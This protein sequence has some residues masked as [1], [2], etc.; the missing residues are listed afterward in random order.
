MYLPDQDGGL[1]PTSRTL[2]A[3][4]SVDSTVRIWQ[5]EETDRDFTCLQS[6]SFGNGFALDLAL[7]VLQRR[8]PLLA[9]G[10]DD[11]KL[12]F[13][14][15]ADDGK[16]VRSLSLT[17]H[18]DWIRAVQITADDNGDLLVATCSQDCFIRLWRVVA[19]VNQELHTVKV[20]EEDTG[21][22]KLKGNTLCPSWEGSGICFSVVLESVMAGH[23]QWVYGLHWQPPIYRDGT[24]YQEQCLLSA[25]MDKTMII[26]K[27]DSESGVW[28]DHVRVGEVGGNT[29]GLYGCQFS[30]DGG[31]ILAHG[32]QGALHLWKKSASIPD[33]STAQWSPSPVVSGHFGGVQDI[34]WEPD[35]GAF[36]MS[37]GLDQTTRLHAPWRREGYQ[38]TWH[39]IARPQVH[40]YDM[41]CLTLVDRY[42]LASG[43]DEKVLRIFDAPRNF[44]ENFGRIAGV[45]VTEA[46]QDRKNSD[47]PEGASVPALGLSNKAVFQGES[48]KAA[49]EREIS[50]PSELYTEIYFNPLELAGPPTEEHLLQNTLWP[51]KQKLYGHSYEIFSVASHP[52]GTIIASACKAS[53][54]EYATILL[55]D[56]TTWRQLG[57]LPAHS[58]TITQLAFS[59]SG[60]H[61]LAVSRD[62][63]WSMFEEKEQGGESNGCPY[64]LVACTDKKTALHSRIIW[65]G[66]WS[67]DDR[68]FATASRDKKV[69]IWGQRS[70][71]DQEDAT[72]SCLGNYRACSVPFDLKDAVTAVDFAP[73]ASTSGSYILAVG[74][75]S[76][77]MSVAQWNPKT[78]NAWQTCFCVQPQLC[79]TM[80]VKRLKWRPKVKGSDDTKP[81]GITHL[82]LASCSSDS[83]VRFHDIDINSL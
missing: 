41:H 82:Q 83:S 8:V 17:G 50:H 81:D 7:F 36:L 74:L 60:R 10:G 23:E 73:V 66:A 80:T 78:P 37:V 31:A 63:T 79:H 61:L 58:L 49:S 53:K 55:W 1:T 12:H 46:L 22:L 75:E 54:A 20:L 57:E 38:T 76:G 25:S 56:T 43:A 62:R 15:E 44:V 77:S 39:E 9:L 24:R 21:E 69:I 64:V 26:W 3:S 34:T 2:I 11:T 71:D 32:Y 51:E 68:Y 28:L 19:G 14:I 16:F 13:Y 33:R 42:R 35:D 30:P 72:P 67:H 65:S 45:D 5:R 4:A 27:L 40:G 29:L 18:E 48:G 59:H 6:L 47:V 70:S 52:S